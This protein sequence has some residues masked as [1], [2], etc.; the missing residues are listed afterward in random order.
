MLELIQNKLIVGKESLHIYKHNGNDSYYKHILVSVMY[1]TAKG[2]FKEVSYRLNEN[3][4][5]KVL[6][7]L[8][9]KPSSLR[10]YARKNAFA[11][12]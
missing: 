5:P 6:Q 10:A 11:S 3:H 7:L 12:Y 1:F 9:E 8:E 4:L 2:K